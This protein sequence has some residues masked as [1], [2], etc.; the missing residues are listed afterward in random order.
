M[1]K[2]AMHCGFVHMC[3]ALWL[4]TYVHCIVCMVRWALHCGY[5]QMGIAFWVST[6]GIHHGCV[7]SIYVCCF[8]VFVRDCSDCKL[9]IAC[10][11]FRTR[12]CKKLDTFLCCTTQPIIEASTGMKFGCFQYHYPELEGTAITMSLMM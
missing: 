10:Q 4:W 6:M 2:H 1:V 5:G 3:N 9:M 11:Q 12:D 8:S 7:C